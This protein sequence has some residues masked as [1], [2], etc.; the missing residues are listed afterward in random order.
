[1]V[2]LVR[3][4]FTSASDPVDRHP[5][6]LGC[7]RRP[8]PSSG[9][10]GYPDSLRT[11]S[12]YRSISLAEKCLSRSVNLNGFLINGIQVAI[13]VFAITHHDFVGVALL[14]RSSVQRKRQNY[15][16]DERDCESE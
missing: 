2:R 16:Y 1:M 3:H 4:Q 14:R 11:Y 9:P 15:E 10:S 12:R 13:E 5:D 6:R 8:R 7:R